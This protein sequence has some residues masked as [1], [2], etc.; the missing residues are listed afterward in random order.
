MIRTIAASAL[1]VLPSLVSA[2]ELQTTSRGSVTISIT[3]PPKPIVSLPKKAQST[4]ATCLRLNMLRYVRVL[5]TRQGDEAGAAVPVERL[6]ASSTDEC[7]NGS[8]AIGPSQPH[9]GLRLDGGD[10]VWIVAPE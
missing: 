2:G 7:P 10:L 1:L 3:I 9:S 6:P 5:A 8:I 4:S